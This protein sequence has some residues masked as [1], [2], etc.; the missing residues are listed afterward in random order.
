MTSE[1]AQHLT[2]SLTHVNAVR[3]TN[4]IHKVSHN[5]VNTRD[6]EITYKLINLQT[7]KITK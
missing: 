7:L 3:M 4:V 5:D 6:K 1:A 2:Q